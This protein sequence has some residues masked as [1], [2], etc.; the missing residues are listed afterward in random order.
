MGKAERER[1]K[2]GERLFCCLCREYGY[3][4]HRTAQFRGNTGAAGDVEGL[5]GIH[6]EVKNQERLNLRDAMAQ[7]IRD[8]EA[9]GKGNIPIVAHKKNNADWLITLRAK[10]FFEI[11]R[12]WEA[13]R[14]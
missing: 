12:E 9:E 7:S 14:D 4:A 3:D 6:V 11:Y 10:D 5:P 1:G 13:G 2:R 8:S